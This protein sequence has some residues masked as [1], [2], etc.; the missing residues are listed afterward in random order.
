MVVICAKMAQWLEGEYLKLEGRRY[1][2]PDRRNKL[3]GCKHITVEKA[4]ACV[5]CHRSHGRDC[6]GSCRRGESAQMYGKCWEGGR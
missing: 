2:R 4:S 3:K 1:V 6:E 5:E